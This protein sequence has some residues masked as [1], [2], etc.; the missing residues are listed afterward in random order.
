MEGC[1]C[2]VEGAGEDGVVDVVEGEYY[3]LGG[4]EEGVVGCHV[5]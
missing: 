4:C 5:F 1:Y 2:D 3:F